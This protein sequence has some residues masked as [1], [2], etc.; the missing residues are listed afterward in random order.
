MPNSRVLT[1]PPPSPCDAALLAWGSDKCGY[2]HGDCIGDGLR[3]TLGVAFPLIASKEPVA[4]AY[5]RE[6]M[7]AVSFSS[8]IK[9]AA[10]SGPWCPGPNE[11]RTACLPT[12]TFIVQHVISSAS[13]GLHTARTL[14]CGRF[15]KTSPRP[16]HASSGSVQSNRARGSP[17][18]EL[19]HFV[20][21][22]RAQEY[23]DAGH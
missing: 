12:C 17:S 16:H 8:R 20:L 21:A 5:V 3:A 11:R 7:H 23:G 2:A 1:L 4:I 19:E 22:E 9:G 14:G 13:A 15:V 18:S 6:T 10:A